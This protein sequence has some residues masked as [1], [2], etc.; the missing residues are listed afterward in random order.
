MYAAGRQRAVWLASDT[1]IPQ[2]MT[3]GVAIGTGGTWIPA[4]KEQSGKFTLLGRPVYFTELMPILGAANDIIF[5][6]V[7]QYSV[8]LR[9][10]LS[11]DVSNIPG[12]TQDLTSLRI[13]VRFDGMATW[14]KPITPRKGDSQSWAVGLAARP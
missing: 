11:I 6:D 14:D 9:K 4:L 3:L 7:S 8:G 10:D 5:C 12:W 13:I 1:T 2:L